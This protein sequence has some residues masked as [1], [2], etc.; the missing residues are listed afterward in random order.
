M[1]IS[2]IRVL[3]DTTKTQ[4]NL[5]KPETS[6]FCT[7]IQKE[8]NEHRSAM[9]KKSVKPQ[10]ATYISRKGVKV[11]KL[12]VEGNIAVGKSSF[13]RILA[14]AYQEWSFVGEP[15]KKWQHVH[16]SSSHGMEN[17]L[18]LLYDNPAR[19]SYTFQTLSCMTRFKTQIDPFS[20]Q[21][22]NQQEPVR[23]FERSVYSDRFVFAKTLFELSHLNDMEWSMY[24]EWHTFL[25]QEFG[26]RAALDGILYLRATP[27]KCFERLQKRARKEE[28]TV[29]Q[30]Y[31]EK[32]HDQHE[33]WLINKNTDVPFA[34]ISNIPVLILEVDEDFEDNPV[35]SQ[36]LMNKVKDFVVSL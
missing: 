7:F 17:L 13:L 31:L 19:W 11:K 12:S 20:E 35:V 34:N 32:L 25:L 33:G 26:E 18:Q 27:V 29:T 2:K 1:F 5:R 23:I 22:L 4:C 3:L 9:S 28:E 6:L 10:C 16:S 24:Q 14:N 8:G 36:S 21:L 15:L 30:Q